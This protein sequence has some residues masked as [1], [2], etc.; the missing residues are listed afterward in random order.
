MRR[1]KASTE[2]RVRYNACWVI[3]LDI[4]N[5]GAA[6]L[7]RGLLQCRHAVEAPRVALEPSSPRESSVRISARRS[8]LHLVS[9]PVHPPASL[10]CV[11]NILWWSAGHADSVEASHLLV[12]GPSDGGVP[13]STG[14]WVGE[15]IIDRVDRDGKEA[16]A[17]GGKVKVSRPSSR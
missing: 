15:E 10:Y 16:E 13:T 1:G 12:C 7:L 17:K 11:D 4:V 6:I 2:N 8:I 3:S 14:V 5:V 9:G